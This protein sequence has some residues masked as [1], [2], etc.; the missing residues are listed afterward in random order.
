[1]I[2]AIPISVTMVA[3]MYSALKWIRADYKDKSR[4][5]IEKE[6][7]QMRGENDETLSNIG[8]E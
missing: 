5:E 2:L 4:Q 8:M 6:F 7:R 1:V 3:S